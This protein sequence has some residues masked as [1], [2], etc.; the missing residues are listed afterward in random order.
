MSVQRPIA[1][2]EGSLFFAPDLP[3]HVNRATES[4]RLREHI[5]DFVEISAVAEG[6]GEHYIGGTHFKV[7][8]GD[9]FYIPVGVSHVFRPL[10]AAPGRD[11]VVYN[12]LFARE[13]LESVLRL[14]PQEEALRAFFH[15]C[16]QESRW[17]GVRDP[18]CAAE[19]MLRRLHDECL[20][21]TSGFSA[22]LHAGLIELLVH[23]HRLV[24]GARSAPSAAD[25]GPIRERLA[26]IG[27]ACAETVR[28]GQLAADLGISPRQLQRR[29]R[30]TAGMSLTEYVQEA[31]IRESCRLL[32]E[33]A[34]PVGS[35]ASA[36][37]Y[38]DVKFFNRLFKRR[39]GMTPGQYR[40]QAGIAAATRT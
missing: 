18:S 9:L 14:L 29:I 12:C 16:E 31:R 1:V 13:R 24:R 22:L 35:I 17:F 40:K 36:V 28:A 19:G 34:N 7:A 11:L 37:G 25:D 20:R 4:F 26:R 3:I 30:E 27:R 15:A 8:K 6:E 39:T 5:H 23:L 38:Q 2:T 32:A 21:R 33:T 10:S